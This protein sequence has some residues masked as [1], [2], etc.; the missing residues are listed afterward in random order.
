MHRCEW[1][2]HQSQNALPCFAGSRRQ[3]Y[4]SNRL[5]P[6]KTVALIGRNCLEQSS[7]IPHAIDPSRREHCTYAQPCYRSLR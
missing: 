1:V 3:G 2:A 4:E 5:A 7:S 6:Y